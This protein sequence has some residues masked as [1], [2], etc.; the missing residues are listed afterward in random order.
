MCTCSSTR[1]S[2]KIEEIF[3]TGCNFWDV[4]MSSTVSS[5]IMVSTGKETWLRMSFEAMTW[6]RRGDCFSLIRSLRMLTFLVFRISTVKTSNESPPRT[7]KLRESVDIIGKTI[8]RAVFKIELLIKTPFSLCLSHVT[9]CHAGSGFPSSRLPPPPPPPPPP[10]PL[11]LPCGTTAVSPSPL[12][13]DVGWSFSRGYIWRWDPWSGRHS[14]VSNRTGSWWYLSS[15]FS[16]SL[17]TTSLWPPTGPSRIPPAATAIYP[18]SLANVRWRMSPQQELDTCWVLCF[19][20]RRAHTRHSSGMLAHLCVCSTRHAD[21]AYSSPSL[22]CKCESGF[23]PPCE[24]SN[25]CRVLILRERVIE[26]AAITVCSSSR[27]S[28]QPD[29]PIFQISHVSDITLV[30][31]KSA[32]KTPNATRTQDGD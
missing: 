9:K 13:S 31:I 8:S 6:L 10:S 2:L 22:N 19:V 3:F 16:S 11:S 28:V 7:K 12:L 4:S 1:A 32:E 23:L 18:P 15:L 29:I 24:E 17:L 21:F 27:M 20:D 30:Y 25:P 5:G 14:K 26:C